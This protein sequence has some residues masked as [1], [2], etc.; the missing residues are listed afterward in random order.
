MKTVWTFIIFSLLSIILLMA[1]R[2]IAK[3]TAAN[4]KTFKAEVKE[5]S[6]AGTKDVLF[7]FR[8]RQATYYINRGLERGLYL[9][10]LRNKLTGQLVTVDYV[11]HWTPL[12]PFTDGRHIAKISVAD[13]V[14]YDE[15][16]LLS[17]K[18]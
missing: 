16:L 11:R 4:C 14:I 3:P 13:E 10:T 9:D 2:P 18:Q 1:L 15:L 7:Q 6:E 8:D 12:D 17:G 5:I